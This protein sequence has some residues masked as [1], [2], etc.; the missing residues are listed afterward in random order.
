[1]SSGLHLGSPFLLCVLE[2]ASRKKEN[3]ILGPF[4][5]FLSLQDHSPTRYPISKSSCFIY[6]S[7]FVVDV[8]EVQS[9][10]SFSNMVK[11]EIANE[12]IFLNDK[13]QIIILKVGVFL[14]NMLYPHQ[15]SDHPLTEGLV[16]VENHSSSEVHTFKAFNS[17]FIQTFH[18]PYFV[19]GAVLVLNIHT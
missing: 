16:L 4:H 18:E 8:L 1:M 5:L 3:V 6:L 12:T 15:N 10:T 13:M 14:I 17:T 2:S 7:G 9:S 11:E 19:A